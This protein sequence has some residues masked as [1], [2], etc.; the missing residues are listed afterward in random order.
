MTACGIVLAAGAGRRY[1][2]PKV[3]ARAAD[4]VLWLEQVVVALREGGCSEVLVVIGAE[5]ERAVS[6]VSTLGAVSAV[7]AAD[8][9]LG[10]SASV[11]AGLAGAANTDADS[12]VI[13]PVDVPGMPASVVAR[14]L[15][16]GAG[17]EGLAR[18]IYDERPGHPVAIGRDHWEL[19]AASVHGDSGA[20]RYLA[21]HAA[22]VVECADLWDG[23]DIDTR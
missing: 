9:E 10:L 15:R 16:A 1:G 18:A 6:I 11:R 8:W 21:T 13:A 3:F 22:V 4:G 20:N 7:V 23:F 5:A 19:V 17:G 12:A 2:Q 14:V